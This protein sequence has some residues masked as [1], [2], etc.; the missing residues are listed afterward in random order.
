MNYYQHHIGDFIRDTAR[1][2]DSQSI[3]YLRMLWVYYETELPLENDVDAI[4]FKIGA[5]ASDVLQILKHFFFLHDDNL[6]HQARCD[7]EILAFRVKSVKAKN[8]ANA[9]WNNA[10]AM[11]TH[12]ERNANEPVFDANQEPVTNNQVKAIVGKPPKSQHSKELKV[13]R[14]DEFWSVYP[15]KDVKLKSKEAWSKH[16]C[17]GIADDVIRGAKKYAESKVGED[18]KFIAMA[19]S[20]LNGNRW[21]DGGDNSPDDGIGVFV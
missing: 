5:N 20:W 9:R 14:F 19:S 15:R 16:N 1:L 13:E 10:N 17:D 3:S 12:T 21:N 4:A 11:R 7:K 6:W 8:S 18:V 2:T